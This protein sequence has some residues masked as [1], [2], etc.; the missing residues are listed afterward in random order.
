MMQEE[1]VMA[2]TTADD[3]TPNHMSARKRKELEVPSPVPVQT[4]LL[5]EK[6]VR[7]VLS[8]LLRWQ[9]YGAHYGPWG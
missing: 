8:T 1:Q 3:E 5:K 9:S 7:I 4:Q 6:K 2:H